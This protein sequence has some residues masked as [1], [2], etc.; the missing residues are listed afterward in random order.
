MIRLVIVQTRVHGM[1]HHDHQIF[2]VRGGVDPKGLSPQ[3]NS[4]LLVAGNRSVVPQQLSVQ[5]GD[6]IMS[7]TISDKSQIGGAQRAW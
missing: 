7:T 6:T 3:V 2:E 1:A 5:F 4:G